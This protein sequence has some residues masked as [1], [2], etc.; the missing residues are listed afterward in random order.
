M[1]QYKGKQ[2]GINP[3][4]WKPK[5]RKKMN[6]SISESRSIYACMHGCVQKYRQTARY[7]YQKWENRELQI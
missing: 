1:T 3:V 4:K 2:Y 7:I 5:R 6:A